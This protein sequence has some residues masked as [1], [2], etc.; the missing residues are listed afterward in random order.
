MTPQEASELLEKFNQGKCSPE[1]L[2]LLNSWYNH[3]EGFAPQPAPVPY[4]IIEKKIWSRVNGTDR[5]TFKLKTVHKWACAAAI[6]GILATSAIYF[7]QKIN[8]SS[9]YAYN[10][11]HDI[12]AGSNQA[13]LTL[14]NGKQI[15]L[16][17]NQKVYTVISTPGISST[18][19]ITTPNGGQY[20]VILPDGT[21]V[22]L[23]AAS[24][25]KYPVTFNG[26]ERRVTLTGEGYFEVT[27]DAKH[28]FVVATLGQTVKVLGTHFGVSS[29][30]NEPVR[31]TLAEGSVQVS[32]SAPLHPVT[33][34]DLTTVLI[35]GQQA[36]NN[37]SSLEK[38]QVNPSDYLGWK[39]GLFI[40]NHTP[41]NNV[42]QQIARWYNVQV[43]DTGLP[44]IYFDGEISR[45]LPLSELLKAIELNN[46]IIFKIE[47]RRI[48]IQK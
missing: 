21:K 5:K 43:D 12:P 39:D 22:Y 38:I 33:S 25:L 32:L 44:A 10:K 8:Q 15:P 14:A 34:R 28:P 40:F 27:K 30:P 16:D 31:T 47:G 24:S 19:T 2:A 11:A 23:N 29:Y 18:N 26:A 48:S 17:S 20:Q 37:G 13:I 42:L 3:L 4:N 9:T 35:P 1:E 41:L 7:I 45:N 6:A 36:I 46:H